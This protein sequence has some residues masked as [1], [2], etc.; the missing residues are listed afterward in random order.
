MT[1]KKEKSQRDSS[2]VLLEYAIALPFIIGIAMTLISLAQ[3]YYTHN[4]LKHLVTDSAAKV[5]TLL[6]PEFFGTS[7]EDIPAR[8]AQAIQND[9]EVS[10]INLVFLDDPAN[11]TIEYVDLSDT[12]NPDNTETGALTVYLD[13]G[14]IDVGGGIF[15]RDLE[16]YVS[17]TSSANYFS[18]CFNFNF[19]RP[20]F[21]NPYKIVL[22]FRMDYEVNFF[23]IFPTTFN[24][25][26][27]SSKVLADMHMTDICARIGPPF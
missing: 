5:A 18:N 25:V 9:N 7:G 26:E 21:F 2:G 24:M 12:Q 8:I 6:R 13:K 23:G 16:P 20:M 19:E 22:T 10:R 4:L 27:S 14:F 15:E 3:V 17:G 11:M 1:N